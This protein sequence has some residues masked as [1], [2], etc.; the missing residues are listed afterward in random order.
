ML[1]LRKKAESRRH[2]RKKLNPNIHLDDE[3][4]T[5][6]A[7]DGVTS[8]AG[9]DTRAASGADGDGKGFSESDPSMADLETTFATFNVIFDKLR[10]P[11]NQERLQASYELKNSLISLAR[12]VSTEQFQ[13]FSNV[14]NNKIFELIHGSDVNEKIGGIL[15][16]DTLIGFYVHTEELPNQTSRLANYLRVLIPS[17]DIEVMRLAA[18]TLGKLAIPGGTLTS[19]FV[20]F[21]VKTCIEWLTTSPENSSSS[22]KQEFRKHASLLIVTALANNSPYLLYPYIN[23]ILDNIWRALRDTKLVIRSDAAVTLGKCLSII[24]HRDSI[25]TKQ[26]YERL[27]KGCVYG[28][29]LN[30]NEAIHA[31]LLVYRELLVLR[32]SFLNSKYDEIYHSTMKYKDHKYDV[33]RK[34]VYAILPLLASF[35]P[36]IFT[37]KYLDQTMVHFLM[38]LKNLNASSANLSD[39]SYILVSIG[40]IAFE[41]GSNITPYMDPILDNIRDGL[42]SKFKNRKNFERELFYCIG[43]LASAVG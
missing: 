5:A 27:F 4:S 42:Q 15:A 41:V 21:E 16:V 17:N 30:T 14:L 35:E 40:D 2:N 7:V 13:R 23:S 12:E 22:S 8:A 18:T 43:K 6:E 19:D 28:L 9:N 36:Q 31:T 38:V 33:I 25:L 26:W 34:E 1:S 29:T 11:S 3:I 24:Q 20:E 10:S 37:N 39:K 32:G